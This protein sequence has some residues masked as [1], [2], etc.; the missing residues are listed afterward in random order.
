[1]MGISSIHDSEINDMCVHLVE[2][3]ASI[4]MATMA[5]G[6]ELLE[7]VNKKKHSHMQ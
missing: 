3:A 5:C 6:C 1:M 7:Q 2:S 4:I